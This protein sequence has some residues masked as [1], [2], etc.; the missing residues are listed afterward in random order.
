MADPTLIQGVGAAVLFLLLLTAVVTL[1]A[2]VGRMNAAFEELA[3]RRPGRARTHAF[4]FP[5]AEVSADGTSAKVGGAWASQYSSNY[6]DVEMEPPAPWTGRLTAHPP[7]HVLGVIALFEGKPLRTG[8]ARFDEAFRVFASPK[9]LADAVLDAEGRETLLEAAKL[10]R[11]GEVLLVLH[12]T[13]LKL[14]RLNVPP[15]A[16][17]LDSLVDF[18]VIL[19]RKAE[20][21]RLGRVEIRIVEAEAEAEAQP[22]GACP[23]C[24]GTLADR[25]VWCRRCATPHHRECWRF[26]RGCAAFAC[27]STAYAKRPPAH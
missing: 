16:T 22:A 18:A 9:A 1:R 27:G 7:G 3:R 26:N 6:V 23:V 10:G 13:A 17:V 24:G 14:R 19:F 21:L 2:H 8:D 4:L 20:D 25:V 12:P 5:E 15:D 11:P